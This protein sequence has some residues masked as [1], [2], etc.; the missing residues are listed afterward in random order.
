ME[1]Q[2]KTFVAI[3]LQFLYALTNSIEAHL[4]KVTLETICAHFNVL[5]ITFFQ[6]KIGDLKIHAWKLFLSNFATMQLSLSLNIILQKL[7]QQLL[8]E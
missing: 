1:S 8:Q 3:G 4:I 7:S 2:W 6:K 5:P